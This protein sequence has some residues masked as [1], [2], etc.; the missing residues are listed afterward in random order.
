[1][2]RSSR[3]AVTWKET[4]YLRTARSGTTARPLGGGMSSFNNRRSR[5]T[6]RQVRGAI[7]FEIDRGP[8]ARLVV[9]EQ[10]DPRN[11]GLEGP[12]PSGSPG[13]DAAPRDGGFGTSPDRAEEVFLRKCVSWCHKWPIVSP[14]IW[15]GGEEVSSWTPTVE[16]PWNPEKSA[17][18]CKTACCGKGRGKTAALV[19]GDLDSA[20]VFR[21]STRTRPPPRPG[22]AVRSC[23]RW[24]R[25]GLPCGD[26]HCCSADSPPA[27]LG[28]RPRRSG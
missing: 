17:T 2:R 3:V 5:L 1:M 24:K 6:G 18:L 16:G 10:Y 15:V 11:P 28:R 13:L 14:Y 9:S 26:C 21:R 20:P 4:V 19:G 7:F 12:G 23:W 22:D 8:C 27:L 25:F